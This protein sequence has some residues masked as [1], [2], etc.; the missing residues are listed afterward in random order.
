MAGSGAFIATRIE[1]DEDT[2]PPPTEKPRQSNGSDRL[3][4][5]GVHPHSMIVATLYYGTEES[6]CDLISSRLQNLLAN[7]TFQIIG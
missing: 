1:D 6:H 2:C 4:H 7:L 3:K 5:W